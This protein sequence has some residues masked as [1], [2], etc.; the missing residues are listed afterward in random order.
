MF[1]SYLELPM[2]LLGTY[3]NFRGE[4][5]A[6]RENQEPFRASH[7]PDKGEQTPII[8]AP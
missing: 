3:P 1:R 2:V 4:M 7:R 6:L 8:A 5:R